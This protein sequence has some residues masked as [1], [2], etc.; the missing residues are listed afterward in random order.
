MKLN[1]SEQFVMERIARD[2][3]FTTDPGR[4]FRINNAAHSLLKRGICKLIRSGCVTLEI[5]RSG[6]GGFIET[7]KRPWSTI[8]ITT[9]G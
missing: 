4:G 1:K 2:G 6:P 9:N 8:R 5:R 7:S 3:Y